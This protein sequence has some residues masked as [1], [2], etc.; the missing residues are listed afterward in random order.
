MTLEVDKQV[1]NFDNESLDTPE[2]NGIS[3]PQMTRTL[4]A[5]AAFR[6]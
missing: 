5:I 2:A 6:G 3:G 1:V 4:N